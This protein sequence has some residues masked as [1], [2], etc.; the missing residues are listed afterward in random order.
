MKKKDRIGMLLAIIIPVLCLASMLFVIL[1]GDR[2]PAYE[3]TSESIKVK[4]GGYDATILVSDIA[5]TNVLEHW[6]DIALRTDGLSTNKVNMGHFRL[7]NGENCMMFI[8]EDGG[9]LLEMR[10]VDGQLYYLNCATKEE[11]LEMID[12]VKAV[13]SSKLVTG[14]NYTRPFYPHGGQGSAISQT[15]RLHPFAWEIAGQARNEGK[16]QGF[17][18]LGDASKTTMS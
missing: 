8:H 7:K 16:E 12:K 15:R 4:G 6:P 17:V 2:G 9:P 13:T 10:T 18:V 3:F 1:R 5:E 11:T 14:D